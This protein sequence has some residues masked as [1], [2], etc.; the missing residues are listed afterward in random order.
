MLKK[1]QIKAKDGII[2]KRAYDADLVMVP[3]SIL[4]NQTLARIKFP[5]EKKFKSVPCLREAY[6]FR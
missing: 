6:K 2:D 4:T 5:C 3:T 1:K